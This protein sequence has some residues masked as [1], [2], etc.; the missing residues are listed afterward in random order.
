MD[1][2]VIHPFPYLYHFRDPQGVCFSLLIGSK[3]A[4]VIDCGYGIFDTKEIIEPLIKVPYEVICTHGHMDHTAGFFRFNQVYIPKNDLNLFYEHNQ[5]EKRLDNLKSAIELGLIDES[6]DKDSYLDVNFNNIKTIEV[7]T[8]IDLGNL[9]VEIINMEGHT[10]GSIG[11]LVREERLLFTGD[12]AIAM[13]WLFLK[14]STTV[15]TYISMLKRVNLLEFAKFI[16]GHLMQ[17]YDKKYFDYYIEVASIANVDNSKK[18]CFKNFY[19]SNSYQY[20]KQY[21]NDTIGIC[22]RDDNLE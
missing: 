21:G 4:L 3:K 11:L 15:K 7:G 12:A 16:P 17:V 18:V 22:F 20:S 1:L 14:E 13:V 5:K 8:I 6:Y 10:K 19:F 9:H 2:K